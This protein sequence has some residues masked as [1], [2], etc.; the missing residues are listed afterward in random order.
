[1]G[2]HVPSAPPG[3]AYGNCL[4]MSGEIIWRNVGNIWVR[5]VQIAMQDY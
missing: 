2:V 5:Y 3:Y 4:G 1:M